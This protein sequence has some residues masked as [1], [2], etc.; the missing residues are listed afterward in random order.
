MNEIPIA[1]VNGYRRGHAC[2][3]QSGP[4]TERFRGASHTHSRGGRSRECLFT[5]R[6][7]RYSWIFPFVLMSL[8]SRTVPV[9]ASDRPGVPFHRTVLVL[10]NGRGFSADRNN[11]RNYWEFPL[12]YLGLKAQYR[13]VDSELPNPNELSRYRAV[14]LSLASPVRH[15]RTLWAFLGATL[16]A[17][18]KLLILGE[19]PNGRKTG[20]GP[21]PDIVRNSLSRMGLHKAGVWSRQDLRYGV[22][23]R[24]MVGFEREPPPFPPIFR[25]LVNAGRSNTLWLG[26]TSSVHDNVGLMSAFVL[27]G[28]FGGIAL[29]ADMVRASRWKAVKVGWVIDPFRFIETALDIPASPRMDLTTLNGKRLFY[30]HVDGDGFETLSEY[31]RN[32]MC[33]EVLYDEVFTRYRLPF[34]ASIIGSQVDPHY[35]GNGERVKWARRI[36]ALPN[37]EA[38]SHT[39]SHPF[40]W[41]PSPYRHEE[42]PI[43][44]RVPGYRFNL[45]QEVKGTLDWMNRELMPPGKK[46]T[47]YQWSGNTRPGPD[48]LRRVW[49][50]PV[51]NINGSDT[52]LSPEAPS[53]IFVSP[54][55]RQ[56]GPYIQFFN[57]DA[58]EFILTHDWKGPFFGY[59]NILGTFRNTETPRRV[60]PINVYIHFYSGQKEASL[61]AL[62]S[63]LDWV[64]KQPIAP[65]F[66][67][68]FVQR[69]Y[70]FVRARYFRI[71]DKG[72][73]GWR[74][75]RYG[76]ETTVRFDHAEGLYPDF[77]RSDGVIGFSRLNRSLYLFL[78]PDL[79]S[80]QVFLTRRKPSVPYLSS[81]TGDV[82]FERVPNQGVR[83]TYMGW[84]AGSRLRI[85]NLAPGKTYRLSPCGRRES[86][87]RAA[88]PGG[89]LLLKNP[90][91]GV[92]RLLEPAS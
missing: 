92:S 7:W 67:S 72:R 3:G 80:V 88:D 37:V 30:S 33:S 43:H 5:H 34:T 31:R 46:V 44:I 1:P 63:V 16:S 15:P 78:S 22:L 48:A 36:F 60:E 26:V 91:K 56:I 90:G 79:P 6:F 69:E 10:F 29:D 23:R 41:V 75:S 53:Y 25:P 12:N 13:N 71:G 27:T 40:Y 55:Y 4:G 89:S 57:S 58:N 64:V 14:V 8:G 20:A 61:R 74:I 85:A 9:Q 28:P 66:T 82:R 45:D 35:E 87:L 38:G 84:E 51:W 24:P 21:E 39:F 54:Y 52:E 59:R 19:M 17:D 77:D 81:A 42:G 70:G 65:V 18:T 86:C 68:D 32:R 83:V 11:F 2:T 62:T 73:T 76:K 49:D 50:Y 47:V